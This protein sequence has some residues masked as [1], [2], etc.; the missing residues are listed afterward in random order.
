MLTS[1][2]PGMVRTQYVPVC[3]M[4]DFSVPCIAAV[5]RALTRRGRHG[6]PNKRTQT[7]ETHFRSSKDMPQRW[8]IWPFVAGVDKKPHQMATHFSELFD[9]FE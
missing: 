8:L 1:P 3:A 7:R 5:I 6:T 9:M 4:Y 2:C